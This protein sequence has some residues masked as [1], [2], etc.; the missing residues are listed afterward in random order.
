MKK[1]DI[2]IS[3]LAGE[4]LAWY[5]LIVFK[6]LIGE[7]KFLFWLLPVLLPI[8]ALIG[9]W[10]AFLVGK[11]F[12]FVFQV[13]KFLLIGVL[14]TLFYLTILNILMSFFGI[15]EGIFYSV[16]VGLSYIIATLAK[17]LGDKLWA[18]EKMEKEEMGKEFGR[19]FMV[20]IIGFGI[21]VGAASLIVNVVGNQF[22][23]SEIIWANIGGIAASFVS[24]L[25]NFLGYKFIVFK[26]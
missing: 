24:A 6:D 11:R 25:W 23:V 21:N 1:I 4:L 13:A 14:A 19:F 12:L 17:Y 15:T 8:M 18:F 16:F 9:I 10:I 3:L 26:K 2:I 22:G 7:M 5:F 20:T